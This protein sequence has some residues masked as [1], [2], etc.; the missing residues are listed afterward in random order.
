MTIQETMWLP[1]H[2][3]LH[4]IARVTKLELETAEVMNTTS[5]ASMGIMR[6]VQLEADVLSNEVGFA[7]DS[8]RGMHAAFKTSQTECYC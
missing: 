2:H 1:H 4:P 8:L 7:T 6:E 5:K 3:A